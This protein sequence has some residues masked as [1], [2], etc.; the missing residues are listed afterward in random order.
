MEVVLG[1]LAIM[2]VAVE[3][4]VLVVLYV[5]CDLVFYIRSSG[6]LVEYVLY[7]VVCIGYGM[8]VHIIIFW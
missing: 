8:L 3:C 5:C 7:M 6:C 2:G 1:V 4:V